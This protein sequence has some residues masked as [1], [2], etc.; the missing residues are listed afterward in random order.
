MKQYNSNQNRSLLEQYEQRALN[1][2]NSTKKKQMSL[3]SQLLS[4][5][6]NQSKP[7]AVP[8][9]HFKGPVILEESER[10]LEIKGAVPYFDLAKQS[11]QQSIANIQKYATV[12][13]IKSKTRI[14]QSLEVNPNISDR[15]IN[16]PSAI[17]TIQ[18]DSSL[19][20]PILEV[21]D[22]TFGK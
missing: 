11:I 17:E 18:K 12:E 7:E 22:F 21:H 4:Y 20:A 5:Q 15:N 6:T 3:E 1:E 14:P 2:L 9:Y 19:D 8:N 10:N 16:M 13:P